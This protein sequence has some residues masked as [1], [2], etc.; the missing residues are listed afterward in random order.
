MTFSV[1]KS[2]GDKLKDM[3]RKDGQ[4]IIRAKLAEY[5]RL[6]KEEFSEGLILPTKDSPNKTDNRSLTTKMSKMN[7]A[8][9]ISSLPAGDKNSGVMELKE[10]KIQDRFQCSRTD[11]FRTF[12]DLERVKAFTHNSVSVYDCKKGGFFSIFSDN[13]TGRFLQVT[14]YER[15]E[16]LWRFKSW[17]ADHYSHVALTFHEE[18]DRTKLVIQQTGVPSQYYDNTMVRVDGLR[19]QVSIS[20]FVGRM[21]TLLFGKYQINLR[22]RI[23]IVLNP[24]IFASFFLVRKQFS[25]IKKSRFP[26][27]CHRA[28]RQSTRVHVCVSHSL[29][30][31]WKNGSILFRIVVTDMT[32]LLIIGDDEPMARERET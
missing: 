22:L 10:V 18:T 2:K 19:S 9:S 6:L 3:M 30:H 4:P 29:S 13:I 7:L 26:M 20:S 14:P 16:M 24:M 32:T 23:S 12:C 28:L 8:P 1:E 5:I 31:P 15:L 17:P 25:S 21:E 11:L 27:E